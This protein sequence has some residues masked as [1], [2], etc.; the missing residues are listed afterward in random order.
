M[1]KLHVDQG[2]II[3]GS[4][5]K[6]SNIDAIRDKIANIFKRDEEVLESKFQNKKERAPVKEITP[7]NLNK[8]ESQDIKEDWEKIKPASKTSDFVTD[9]RAIKPSFSEGETN[10][11]GKSTLAGALNSIFNP[12][13]L[14]ETKNSEFTDHVL[15]AG[16]EKRKAAEAKIERPRDWEN[17]LRAK[18]SNDLKPAQMGFTPNRSSLEQAPIPKVE[19]QV[20]AKQ[21]ELTKKSIEAGKEAAK[22]KQAM[23]ELLGKRFEKDA[24]DTRKWEDRMS[25]KIAENQTREIETKPFEFKLAQDFTS[26]KGG[27]TNIDLSG[28][29]KT[30]E[31]PKEIKEKSI[32]ADLS[33]LT[34][35]RQKREDDR[36][37][38]VVQKPKKTT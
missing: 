32:K 25:D 36:S 37:W 4:G 27:K 17:N 30:P 14:S 13:A 20:V 12:D 26:E 9:M 24:N 35:K 23:D 16:K 28:L 29:F 19:L 11:G 5:G 8:L 18:S 7:K 34:T 31:N 10:Y 15:N 21:K 3:F 38:E 22:I 6:K 33:H 2:S 1:S